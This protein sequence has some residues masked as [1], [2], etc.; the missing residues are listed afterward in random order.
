M[1]GG[2]SGTITCRPVDAAPPSIGVLT[3]G[4]GTGADFC[5]NLRRGSCR[6]A[7]RWGRRT[8]C[9]EAQADRVQFENQQQRELIGIAL[10]AR[11]RGQASPD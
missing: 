6:S 4:T 9:C 7:R 8:G 10:I 2:L 3:A 11:I 1:R 5:W